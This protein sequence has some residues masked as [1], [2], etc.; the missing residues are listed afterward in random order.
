MVTV[1]VT[2]RADQEL[3]IAVAS[4]DRRI[5]DAVDAPAGL[6]EPAGDCS[7]RRSGGCRIA[8]DAALADTVRAYFELGLDQGDQPSVGSRQTERGGEGELQR[9]E[10]DIGDDRL[11][12]LRNVDGGEVAGVAAFQRHDARI[13]G[14]LRVELAVADIDGEDLRR[15]AGEQDLGEAAGRGS[16]VERDPS[17]GVIAERV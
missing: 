7:G 1:S 3:A 12:R 14:E 6:T 2:A 17:G 4:G 16:D 13:G 10:T 5:G 15:P 9:D 8:D 11:D